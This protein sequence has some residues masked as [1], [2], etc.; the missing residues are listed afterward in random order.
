VL[1]AHA[2]CRRAAERELI[3][4]QRLCTAHRKSSFARSHKGENWPVAS[5]PGLIHVVCDTHGTTS[6]PD[7]AGRLASASFGAGAWAQ[8]G[9]RTEIVPTIPHA[10]IIRSLAFDADASHLVSAD[11]NGLVKLWDTRTRQLLRARVWDVATGNP[12][13]TLTGS[14]LWETIRNRIVRIWDTGSGALLLSLLN[15]ANG[16]WIARGSSTRPRQERDRCSA[17]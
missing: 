8:S 16:E 3:A 17:L 11:S 15:G 9:F 4:F 7:R 13:R 5:E 12:V 14:A 10:Q 1:P 2:C 6:R